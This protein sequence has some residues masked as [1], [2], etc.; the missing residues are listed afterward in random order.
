MIVEDHADSAQILA[1][2]LTRKGYR[3]HIASNAAEAR[4][5]AKEHAFELLLCDLGLPDADGCDLMRELLG[6]YGLAAIAITGH[7]LPADQARVAA[8]GV[9]HYLLK[10]VGFDQLMATVE[11]ALAKRDGNGTA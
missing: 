7:N 3:V 9:R 4:A 10:P 5:L 1:R 2:V 6:Q 8:A 11:A